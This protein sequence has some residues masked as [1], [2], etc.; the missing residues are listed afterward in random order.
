MQKWRDIIVNHA[1][2]ERRKEGATE[3]KDQGHTSP[4]H[5]Y[6]GHEGRRQDGHSKNESI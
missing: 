4:E 5:R 3:M 1:L 6:E 2:G